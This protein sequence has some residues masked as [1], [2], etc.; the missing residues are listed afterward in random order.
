MGYKIHINNVDVFLARSHLCAGAASIATHSGSSLSRRHYFQLCPN[1]AWWKTVNMLHP[2]LF[3]AAKLSNTFHLAFD[4]FYMNLYINIYFF[5]SAMWLGSFKTRAAGLAGVSEVNTAP[6]WSYFTCF[7]WEKSKFWYSA[8]PALAKTKS[9]F[10]IKKV[11]TNERF[12][13]SLSNA[14]WT[15]LVKVACPSE[16][17]FPSNWIEWKVMKQH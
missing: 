4:D 16:C 1:C 11:S 10:G 15:F 9:A 5:Y 6:S 13:A 14:R 3:S 8:L 2:S 17:L 7:R 12:S